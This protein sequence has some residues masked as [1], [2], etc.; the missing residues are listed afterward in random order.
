[1]FNIV[2][3]CKHPD[4]KWSRHG[5]GAKPTTTATAAPFTFESAVDQLRSERQGDVELA[6]GRPLVR[7]RRD[8]QVL[9]R[10]PAHGGD[11]PRH[12]E[13]AP[14]PAG[15]QAIRRRQRRLP[16]C[17]RRSLRSSTGK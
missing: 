9:R 17:S 7:V 4:I 8:R 14:A 1:M 16:R 11:E 13:R 3:Q 12:L 6:P 5:F 15:G 10:P 2:R